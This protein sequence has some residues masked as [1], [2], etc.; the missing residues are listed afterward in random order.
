MNDPLP[1]VY[2]V[3]RH[4][5]A[6]A[7]LAVFRQAAE[8]KRESPSSLPARSAARLAG[9]DGVGSRDRS[10]DGCSPRLPFCCD[11]PRVARGRARLLASSLFVIVRLTR[12]TLVAVTVFRQAA[13]AGDRMPRH[14]RRRLVE[15][16]ERGVELTRLHED[17]LLV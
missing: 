12:E 17:E 10:V 7:A 16:G 8:R 11:Q 1:A 5:G 3:W 15:H 9:V 14:M 13:E 2:A 6:L 4:P